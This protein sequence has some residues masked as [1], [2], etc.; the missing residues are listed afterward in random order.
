MPR[1]RMRDV[2]FACVVTLTLSCAGQ[3]P[4]PIVFPRDTSV[5]IAGAV[6]PALLDTTRWVDS[7]LATLGARQRVA[8]MV[9][10]WM[11]GDYTSADD[12]AF[13]EIVGWVEREG[14]GGITMSLGTPI[15]VA[16][17]LNYLQRRARVPLIVASDLEP[18]LMRLEAAVFPHYLLET[19]G[20]TSFPTAMAIAATARD[21]DAFDV[22]R[23]I[24]EEARASGIQVNF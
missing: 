4:A 23:A 13:A 17:K 22:A 12:T 10:F 18:S 9:M 21:S 3:V 8:Q 7:T 14:A 19:G 15:E 11:L 5:A 6:P 20:A 16:E 24:A 2:S 1:P